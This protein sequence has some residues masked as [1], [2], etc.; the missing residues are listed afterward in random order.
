MGWSPFLNEIT[1]GRETYTLDE[2]LILGEKVLTTSVQSE[3][4]PLPSETSLS[5]GCMVVPQRYSTEP[6]TQPTRN[7]LHFQGADC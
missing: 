1:S 6:L 5:T 7:C 2:T 3:K 4:S